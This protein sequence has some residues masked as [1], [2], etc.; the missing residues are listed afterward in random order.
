MRIS[1]LV[2]EEGKVAA[3]ISDSERANE[4]ELKSLD[5]ENK[6]ELEQIQRKVG[7]VL[8]RKDDTCRAL[9]SEL[10]ELRARNQQREDQLERARQLALMGS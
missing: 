3:Q 10:E 2:G 1:E 9:M 7:T 5:A 6:Q 8:A 4:E